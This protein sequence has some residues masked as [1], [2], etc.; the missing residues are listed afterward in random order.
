MNHRYLAHSGISIA[1]LATLTACGGSGSDNPAASTASG[2]TLSGI[3]AVG[4]PI[5]GGTVTFVCASGTGTATT[6]TDGAYTLSMSDGTLPCLGKVSTA[7]SGSTYYSLVAEGNTANLTPITDLLVGSLA[8]E[9]TDGFY[10]TF[11]TLPARE[12]AAAITPDK[13]SAA[14]TAAKDTLKVNGV[15]GLDSTDL[16]AGTIKPDD[17]NDAYDQALLQLTGKDRALIKTQLATA[18]DDSVPTLPKNLLDL[19]RAESCAALRSTS[20]RRV[21]AEGVDTLR[22]DAEALTIADANG[23]VFLYMRAVNK[24][25]CHFTL[26][27]DAAMQTQA[28]D[29]MVAQSGV[30]VIR[31]RA[32]AGPTYSMGIAFPVQTGYT[33]A[34]V[35]GKWNSLGMQASSTA[36]TYQAFFSKST[37]GT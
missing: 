34:D 24:D 18:A 14:Q 3:A 35:A 29:M 37:W 6:G 23:V 5:D 25:A 13:V 10:D 30:A 20:L 2:L 17:P 19:P 4:A 1:M 28:G 16:L 12:K 11:S 26:F 22:V 31:A 32:S 36:G 27:S 7:D 15:S 21:S 8:G 33:L 9:F